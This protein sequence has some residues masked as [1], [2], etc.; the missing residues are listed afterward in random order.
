[1]IEEKFA[2]HDK[3]E[4]FMVMSFHNIKKDLSLFNEIIIIRELQEKLYQ[5]FHIL[6]CSFSQNKIL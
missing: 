6:S 3:E 1:M 5:L 4:I 2:T